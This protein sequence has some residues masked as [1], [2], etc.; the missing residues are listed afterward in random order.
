M[1][2]YFPTL[3]EF[4]AAAVRIIRGK[5]KPSQTPFP[6]EGTLASGTLQFFATTEIGE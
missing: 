2:R 1:R 6:L 5:P 3:P 4:T